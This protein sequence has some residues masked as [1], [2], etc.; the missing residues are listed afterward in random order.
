M[1]APLPLP[2]LAVPMPAPPAARAVTAAAAH[3]RA[4]LLMIAVPALWSI[5]GVVTRHLSPQLLQHGRFEVSFWRSAFAAL[6]VAGYLALVRGDLAAS[7]RRAGAAGL[8][9]GLMWATMFVSFMLALTLTSTANTLLVQSLMPLAT[10]LLARAVLRTPIP[11][12]TWLAIFVAM[13]GIGWMVA[14][15]L[16]LGSAATVLGMAIAFGT[17][18]AGAANFVLLKKCGAAV[19]LVPAVFV[20]GLVSALAMLPWAL[21]FQAGLRDLALLAVLGFFQLGLPC[22]LLV[23]AARHLAPTEIALLG[24]I[25]VLLGPLWAWAGAGEAPAAA[26]IAGG[27]FVLAALV[28]NEIVPRGGADAARRRDEARGERQGG[29]A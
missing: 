28:A 6:F 25:E 23:A 24:L 4:V 8:A 1:R 20:G 5:A 22:I 19:D 27:A 13:L 29:E 10:A 12:R 18:L 14:G 26:T 7:L 3:R 11:R 16:A 21:P 15:S 9:S 17:P 2:D